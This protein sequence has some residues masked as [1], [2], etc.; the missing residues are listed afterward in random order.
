MVWVNVDKRE[1]TAT[2]H[3]HGDCQYVRDNFRG[4]AFKGH[5]R[6]LRDGGWLTFENTDKAMEGVGVVAPRSLFRTCHRCES[7]AGTAR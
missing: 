3:T 1:R 4:T 6:I 7:L 5:N 2:A